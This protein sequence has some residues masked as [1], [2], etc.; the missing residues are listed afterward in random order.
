MNAPIK[1]FTLKRLSENDDIQHTTRGRAAG[2]G[3]S[4]GHDPKA[5]RL[6]IQATAYL[7]D[8]DEPKKRRRRAMS[9]VVLVLKNETKKTK[10]K[11]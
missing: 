11:H 1:D 7:R 2:G 6:T 10:A 3:G 5:I 8:A 9:S 4:I